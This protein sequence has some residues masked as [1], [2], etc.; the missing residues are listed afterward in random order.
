MP[1]DKRST[2]RPPTDRRVRPVRVQRRRDRGWRMPS[3]AV[4]VG[5]PTRWGNPW[6]VDEFGAAVAV[7]RYRTALLVDPARV[8]AV[9][10]EL[11]GWDLACWCPLE[12]PCH[13]E[14]LLDLAHTIP[15]TTSSSSSGGT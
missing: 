13:A 5:R 11:G 8:G 10:R 1:E 2:H 9:R 12:G 14:V 6:P 4:Y 15:P 7:T 3:G